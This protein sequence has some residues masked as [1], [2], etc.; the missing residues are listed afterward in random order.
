MRDIGQ[1]PRDVDACCLSLFAPMAARDTARRTWG[2]A[3]IWLGVWWRA[4]VVPA[5]RR[6]A[7]VWVGAAIVS[8]VVFGPTGLLPNDLTTLALTRPAVGLVLG[9][10]WL[11][12]F[13]PIARLVVRADAA[14]YLR[15]L[16]SPQA[17]VLAIRGAVLVG[18]QLPWLAL[19]LAGE[20]LR[21]LGVVVL[22]SVPIALVASWR[23]R[24]VR[25]R[26][27]AWR[28][29]GQA[30]R[31]VYLRALRRRASDAILRGAGLA[32]LAGLTAG[33]FIRNNGLVGVGAAQV[34]AAVLAVMLVPAQVGALIVLLDAH[35][36]SRW[37]A[38]ALG[39]TEGARVLAMVLAIL[40]VHG[41]AALLAVVSSTLVIGVHAPTLGWLALACAT[42]AVGAALGEAR[43]MLTAEDSPA[44]A[45]RTVAGALTVA[46]V[47]VACLVLF[48]VP[49]GLLAIL[50]CGAFAIT[51]VRT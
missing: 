45:A 33:L 2:F 23:A 16:P 7:A 13:L 38:A 27:P 20:G 40:A 9:V 31:A 8:A 24:P 4:V 49:E 37:L 28:S 3:V 10:T 41:V 32:I 34:G 11:L 12:V 21:G 17:A 48:G 26:W 25:T 30:L 1:Y 15:S 14:S 6:A 47:I 51:A 42:T 43:V 22:S 39:I 36:Q 18:L 46:I 35:R 29:G 5:W 19:W 50:A 44:I